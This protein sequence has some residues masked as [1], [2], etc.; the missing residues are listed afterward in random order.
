MS[1][2]RTLKD[3][4]RDLIDNRLADLVYNVAFHCIREHYLGL[5]LYGYHDTISGPFGVKKHVH[6]EMHLPV[7]NPFNGNVTNYQKRFQKRTNTRQDGDGK[8]VTSYRYYPTFMSG[9]ENTEAYV[10]FWDFTYKDI[11]DLD[12]LPLETIPDGAPIITEYKLG[13]DRP[14]SYADEFEVEDTTEKQ[15]EKTLEQIASTE[16]QESVKAGT[17]STPV[18]LD[19]QFEQKFETRNTDRWQ[20]NSNH[21]ELLRGKKPVGPYAQLVATITDK[22]VILRQPVRIDGQ[23]EARVHVHLDSTIDQSWSS[24]ED[25]LNTLR[26]FGGGGRFGSFYGSKEYPQSGVYEG[27]TGSQH[28]EGHIKADGLKWTGPVAED[29]IEKNVIPRLP[30]ALIEIKPQGARTINED[31]VLRE[32]PFVS[33]DGTVN[34]GDPPE[35]DG[36]YEK[37]KAKPGGDGFDLG[38]G[39]YTD[40]DLGGGI[41]P[42]D[43]PDQGVDTTDTDDDTG[44]DPTDDTDAGMDPTDVQDGDTT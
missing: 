28:V 19:T 43:D 17:M 40:D 8:T 9:H 35:G 2:E 24:I 10:E 34:R 38:G 14:K 6:K 15:T 25:F 21:R 1:Y 36:L 31:K 13:N 26:G 44:I 4:F 7:G 5:Y 18:S 42:T 20:T 41:D 33:K 37:Y 30:K 16:F 11:S 29:V 32:Y 23:L 27:T 39:D 12:I 22:P 3:T